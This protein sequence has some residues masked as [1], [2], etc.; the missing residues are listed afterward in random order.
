M[1]Q[2]TNI[3]IVGVGGQ[4]IVL[5]GDVI[6]MAARLAG[7]EAKASE[8]HGMSQ[9]G[10]SVV[11]E[12]RF[13]EAVYSPLIPPPGADYLMAFETLEGLRGLERLRPGGVAIVNTQRI[14]PSSVTYGTAVYPAD[15]E[16]QIAARCPNAVLLDAI[17]VAVELGNARAVNSVLMG[18]LAGHGVLPTDCWE[19]A[20]GKIVKPRFVELNITAFRRGLE[21]A[22]AG[23]RSA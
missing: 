21:L 9:R 15:A 20:I 3:L 11:S 17:A 12:V 14:I 4:G 23:V 6:G 7:L 5:A 22:P 2:T 16:A 19:Q 18:V 13:G 1:T 10:G 8:V